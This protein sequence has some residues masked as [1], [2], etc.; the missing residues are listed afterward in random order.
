MSPT[1]S[2]I[3]AGFLGSSSGIPA[4]TFPTKSAPTSAPFVKIPPP[5]LA[6]IE[7]N[8]AQFIEVVVRRGRPKKTEVKNKSGC[9]NKEKPAVKVEDEQE[10]VS[11]IDMVSRD[12]SNNMTDDETTDEHETNEDEEETNEDEEENNDDSSEHIEVEV[13]EFEYCG[14]TYFKSDI[15]QVFDEEWK[16]IGTWDDTNETIDFN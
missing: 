8:E 11:N 6:N 14:K 15:G 9:S 3:T 1:L 4:S 10:D 7:I 5:N 16:E 13:K 2:A 12:D